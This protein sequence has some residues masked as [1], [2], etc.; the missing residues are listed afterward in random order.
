MVQDGYLPMATGPELVLPVVQ[1]PCLAGYVGVDVI[2]EQS[3]R[4]LVRGRGDEV[5]VIGGEI[6]EEMSGLD[7]LHHPIG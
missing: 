6:R 4:P 1:S 7:P 5:V 2:H 3:Q